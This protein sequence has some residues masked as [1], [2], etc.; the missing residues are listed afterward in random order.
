VTEALE[1]RIRALIQE[2]RTAI[3]G[4]DVRRTYA[5]IAELVCIDAVKKADYATAQGDYAKAQGNYAKTQGD[6]AKAQGNQARDQTA[7]N[8]AAIHLAMQQIQNEFG[9]IK[10]VINDTENGSLLLEIK[11]LLSDM[12]RIATDA[13]ID[14]IIAGSYVDEDDEGSIF[15]VASEQDIDDIISGSYV[16]IPAS[17]EVI[18]DAELRAIVEQSF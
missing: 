10:D 18:E 12:Y 8:I 4:E 1:Q 3:Y 11:G 5:D 2:F 15:D 16:D 17:E 6:Y 7:E 14:R 9:D 13:D